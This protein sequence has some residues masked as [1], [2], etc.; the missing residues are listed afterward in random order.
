M[1]MIMSRF[2]NG[3]FYSVS[4]EHR[5]DQRKSK[6]TRGSLGSS[7]GCGTRMIGTGPLVSHFRPVVPSVAICGLSG[8]SKY[9]VVPLV[10]VK[11]NLKKTDS[12]GQTWDVFHHLI[13]QN[14]ET[15]LVVTAG[16]IC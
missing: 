2:H 14:A 16:E 5:I 8:S 12:V 7:L 11:N 4:A 9:R 6:H 1:V 10:N 15:H 13:L 3:Q